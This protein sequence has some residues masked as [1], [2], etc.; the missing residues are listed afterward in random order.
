MKIYVLDETEFSCWFESDV[1]TQASVD[2][3]EAAGGSS[4]ALAQ[5]SR[6]F[7]S[8]S[9]YEALKRLPRATALEIVARLGEQYGEVTAPYSKA[10]SL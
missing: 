2:A 4:W 8:E 6:Q 10:L 3:F 1:V 7:F 5:D 9:D